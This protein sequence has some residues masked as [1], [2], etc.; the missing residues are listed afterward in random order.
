MRERLLITIQMPK[1]NLDLSMS[2]EKMHSFK[3][4]LVNEEHLF[5]LILDLDGKSAIIWA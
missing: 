2:I 5:S 4:D 1:Y 3:C